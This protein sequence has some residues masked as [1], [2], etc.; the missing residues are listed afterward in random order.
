MVWPSS[1]Y[2]VRGTCGLLLH[3]NFGRYTISIFVCVVL[4]FMSLCVHSLYHPWSNHEGGWVLRAFV[5]LPSGT[6]LCEWFVLESSSLPC[7]IR[8][9]SLPNPWSKALH[10]LWYPSVRARVTP[11]S[12]APYLFLI[13]VSLGCGHASIGQGIINVPSLFRGL[14]HRDLD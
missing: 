5:A 10:V 6:L 2:I 9:C 13:I 12:F 4:Y 3:D 1:L 11:R 8:P 14:W 7:S